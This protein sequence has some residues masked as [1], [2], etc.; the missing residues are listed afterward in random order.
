MAEPE[1]ARTGRR[2]AQGMG[3][4]CRRGGWRLAATAADGDG[5]SEGGRSEVG[6]VPRERCRQW[7]AMAS[8][9]SCGVLGEWQ[10]RVGREVPRR[11]GP[12]WRGRGGDWLA[13]GGGGQDGPG[14]LARG[15]DGQWAA[16]A[17]TGQRPG[18][19]GRKGGPGPGEASC[20]VGAGPVVGPWGRGGA[21]RGRAGLAGRGW[22]RAVVGQGRRPGR[23][24][25]TA[26]AAGGARQRPGG[27][28][29]RDRPTAGRGGYWWRREGWRPVARAR[30]GRAVR[31]GGAGRV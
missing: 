14:L 11:C 21:R 28:Q 13:R 27:G 4:V 23:L 25:E 8:H 30:D 16:E 18:R 20:R 29:D 15:C 5:D 7:W 9:W 22:D 12:A 17:A 3:K 1:R 10:V 2:G 31:R 26:P 19:D 24:A 6:G